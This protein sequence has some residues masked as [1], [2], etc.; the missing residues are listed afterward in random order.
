MGLKENIKNAAR[1]GYLWYRDNLAYQLK[2]L[3]KNGNKKLAETLLESEKNDEKSFKKYLKESNRWTIAVFDNVLDKDANRVNLDISRYILWHPDRFVWCTHNDVINKIFE[4]A[5]S[6]VRG[7][8][9]LVDSIIE[10]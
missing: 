3:R 5:S 4:L 6:G 9:W 7:W 10:R 1:E 2:E 8:L